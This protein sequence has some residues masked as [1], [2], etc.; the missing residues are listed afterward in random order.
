MCILMIEMINS[1]TYCFADSCCNKTKVRLST[2]IVSKNAAVHVSSSNVSINVLKPVHYSA[3]PKL[4]YI[5]GLHQ[6]VYVR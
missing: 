6:L 4:K 3:G 1:A 5:V 2:G